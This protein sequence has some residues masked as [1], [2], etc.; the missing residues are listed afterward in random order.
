L[1]AYVLLFVFALLLRLAAVFLLSNFDT[2]TGFENE[3]IALNL[4]N[5]HGYSFTHYGPRMPSAFM[6]PLYTL[7]LAGNFLLFGHKWMPVEILQSLIG[8]LGAPL[9]VMLAGRL[10]CRKTAW[11]AGLL[12][13]VYPFYV[14]W[15]T[16][17]QALT[18]EVVLLMGLVLAFDRGLFKDG[19]RSAV[20]PGVLLGLGGLSKTLYLVF[21]PSFLLWSKLRS[22]YP[23]RRSLAYSFTVLAVGLA[24]IAPWTIRN[25]VR[26]DRFVPVTD[27]TGF[28]LWLGNN[29]HA[30]G[31]LYTSD[32][33]HITETI[34]AKM[35]KKLKKAPSSP[36]QDDIFKERAVF[37]IKQ[38]PFR[39]FELVPC[40]LSALW[41]FDPYMPSSYGN[42]RAIAYLTLLA[43]AVAGM[44]LSRRKARELSIIYFQFITITGVYAVFFGQS[45]FRM[46]LEWGLILFAAV[47]VERVLR[48]VLARLDTRLSADEDT[49]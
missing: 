11:I 41:Y 4:V 37:F 36:A 23:W 12:Y 49:V 20:L 34:P 5:G 42:F 22:Q 1:Q 8:A 7:F 43:F 46:V 44:V 27:N 6:Y 33:K 39:F 35:K 14:Y 38:N 19:L 3:E 15:V 21:F 2:V 40:R 16:K 28:N 29:P 48:P 17:G 45:R 32:G 31:G 9:I 13:S 47:T 10:V 30:A 25:A 18:I 26:L 24:V